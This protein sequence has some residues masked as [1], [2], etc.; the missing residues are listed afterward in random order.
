MD[1]TSMYKTHIKGTQTHIDIALYICRFMN[2][3]TV[4]LYTS[5]TYGLYFLLYYCRLVYNLRPPK[6]TCGEHTMLGSVVLLY[7]NTVVQF[8]YTHTLKLF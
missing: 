6:H 5:F 3:Y 7:V 1:W 8:L 4:L 2:R